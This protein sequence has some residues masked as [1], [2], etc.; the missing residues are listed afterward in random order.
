MS[1]IFENQSAAPLVYEINSRKLCVF[2]NNVTYP[3]LFV[4]LSY[5]KLDKDSVVLSPPSLENTND[6]VGAY[7]SNLEALYNLD[8]IQNSFK[9]DITQTPKALYSVHF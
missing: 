1:L 2:Y 9:D 5:S 8:H 4:S 7:F 3:R 6:A